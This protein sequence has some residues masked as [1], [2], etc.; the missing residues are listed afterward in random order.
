M[1]SAWLMRRLWIGLAATLVV[2]FAV[3]GWVGSRIYQL[4][5]PIP[6]RVVTTDGQTVFASGDIAAGQDVWRSFGGMELGSI[7]G[8]GSYVAPDWTAD[9]LHR[10]ALFVLDTWSRAE[11]GRPWDELDEEKRAGL[12]RRLADRMKDAGYD[13]STGTLTIDPVR[14]AAF[15]ANASHYADVFANGRDVYAIPKNTL[16]DPVKVRAMSAFFFWSAW[17]AV[18]HRPD[19]A[20]SYTNN[21]PHEPLVGNRPTGTTVVWSG[22]SILMLLGGIGAMATWHAIRRR[23]D[24]EATTPPP[25]SDPLL[26]AVATPSQRAVMKFFWL[27]AALFL[28]QILMGVVVAHYGV[29]GSAFYGIPLAKYLPYTVARTW[30]LQIGIFWIATAWLATGLYVGPAVGHEPRFQRL[31]VNV[32]FGALVFVA[33]GSLAGEWPNQNHASPR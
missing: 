2:S 30:H 23:E 13:A 18:A 28:V 10:E 1:H 15:D 32:L 21:W 8:H 7:W 31:G 16:G 14:A 27:T 24:D 20:V 11:H 25:K 26:E 17:A 12:S 3:L 33:V 4:A 5:P 19:E 6:S 22:V 29:E 9:W